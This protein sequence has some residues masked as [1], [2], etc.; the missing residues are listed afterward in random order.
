MVPIILA[1]ICWIVVLAIVTALCV[2]ARRG[3][4]EQPARG[5]PR[6]APMASL[7]APEPAALGAGE[8][9]VPAQRARAGERAPL[10]GVGGAAG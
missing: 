3:D 10:A 6:Q 9:R 7:H 2:A 4:V 8:I 5:E 1:L